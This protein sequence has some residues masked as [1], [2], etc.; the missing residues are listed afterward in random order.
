MKWEILS[1]YTKSG[2]KKHIERLLP[3]LPPLP[4]Y[5][6]VVSILILFITVDLVNGGLGGHAAVCTS[7]TR[8]LV[9]VHG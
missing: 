6:L 2:Y 8:Q 7:E 9:F 5:R 4:T 3:P 1:L